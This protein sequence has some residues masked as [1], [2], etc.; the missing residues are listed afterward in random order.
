MTWFQARP[1][2]YYLFDP[3][4]DITVSELAMILAKVRGPLGVEIEVFD[5]N[6]IPSNL[7]RHFRLIP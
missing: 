5:D 4:P 3:Q 7:M 2:K 6:V 1:R